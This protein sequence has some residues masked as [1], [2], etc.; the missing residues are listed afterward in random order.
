MKRLL[1]VL[2]I[3]LFFNI[4]VPLAGALESLYICDN[5]PKSY[6]GNFSWYS[7]K[8]IHEFSIAI[9]NLSSDSHGNVIAEGNGEFQVLQYVAKIRIKIQITP[10]TLRFEMWELSPTDITVFLV[11]DGS[12]IGTISQ[13]LRTIKAV[14]TTISMGAQGD[15]LLTAQ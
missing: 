8:V 3:V 10:A 13:D 4:Y 9:T 2:A 7:D 5:L 15:L 12:Y 6:K 1:I 11:T 14:W